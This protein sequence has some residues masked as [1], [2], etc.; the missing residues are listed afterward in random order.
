MKKVIKISG[1]TMIINQRTGSISANLLKYNE[2]AEITFKYSKY[3]IIYNRI[4]KPP[5]PINRDEWSTLIIV[6][7]F[8][9]KVT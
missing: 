2:M 7:V 6:Y 1:Y 3:Y 5:I 4:K 9:N 8:I